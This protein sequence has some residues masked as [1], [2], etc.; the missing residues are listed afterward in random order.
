[1]IEV[2]LDN[3][4]RHLQGTLK[5]QL[6]Y[7][8]GISTGGGQ[9]PLN[10]PRN[11]DYF[12]HEPDIHNAYVAPAIFVVPSTTDRP[13]EGRGTE[14][15]ALLFQEHK[16][17]LVMLVEEIDTE[18]LQRVALRYARALD[19]CLHDQEITP[20]GINSR[21]TKCFI[22]GVSYGEIWDTANPDQRTFR[23]DISVELLVKHWDSFFPMP[24]LGGSADS[25]GSGSGAQQFI[26][27]TNLTGA[28]NGVNTLFSLTH[29]LTL[30]E[31]AHPI[32]VLMRGA[33]ILTWVSS[34]PSTF[35]YRIQTNGTGNA[36]VELGEAPDA[37]DVVIVLLAA[38]DD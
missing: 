8:M 16:I 32:M 26:G 19:I 11:E 28:S 14:Y 10:T 3:I 9:Y 33:N 27:Q 5:D 12:I 29:K 37:N 24:L 23:K 15:N 13:G 25:S 18:R 17:N 38:V 1:M 36:V 34:G 4:V 6:D 31:N 21:T 30:D 22:T 35:E 2:I 20:N 7:V